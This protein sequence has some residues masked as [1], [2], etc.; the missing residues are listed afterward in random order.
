MGFKFNPLTG[1]LD[2]TN[3]PT[4]GG[5][6]IL[7]LNGLST[8]PQSLAI[9][10][11]ATSFTP[12][13]ASA[14]STHTLHIP[15]ASNAT[16][17]LVN[18]TGQDFYGRK[19]F[20]SESVDA[21]PSLRNTVEGTISPNDTVDSS[22]AFIAGV[23]GSAEGGSGIYDTGQLNGTLGFSGSGTGS[24]DIAAMVGV[25]AWAQTH[26]AYSGNVN[27]IYGSTSYARHLAPT[28][29]T[30]VIGHSAS[31][32]TEVVG[33]TQAYGLQVGS[34]VGG[35]GGSF[36]NAT[37]LHIGG[38][39]GTTEAIGIDITSL[40]G[41]SKIGIRANIAG[42]S[43]YLRDLNIMAG[44][45]L[46]FRDSDS[47]NYVSF[48]GAS[49]IASDIV[50]TLPSADGTSGQVLSTNGS[51][52]LSWATSSGGSSTFLALTD[53]P[54]S[55]TGQTL[56][57]VRVNAG[58][59]ALEFYTPSTTLT[60]GA[61]DT[62]TP[63][64]NALV[65]SG[66]SLYAQSAST[67]V[68]GMVNI[69]SQGFKGLKSLT[70]TL[71][72]PASSTNAFIVD[73][74]LTN[75]SNSSVSGVFSSSAS[76]FIVSDNFNHT[77]IGYLTGNYQ[78]VGT[79]GNGTYSNMHL[80]GSLSTV[81][82]SG[83]STHTS[84]YGAVCSV[85]QGTASTVG[86]LYGHQV[87]IANAV[88]STTTDMIGYHASVT[89]LSAAISN[90]YAFKVE[91]VSLSG[92]GNVYGFYND[93][94]GS[95]NV[96]SGTNHGSI[97]SG[98]N[99]VLSS[100]SHATK[101]VV[102]IAAGS[103]LQL[104]ATSGSNQTYNITRGNSQTL[105][106][107]GQKSGASSGFRYF[108]KDGDG[109]DS[110][111]W[112]L[113][114]VGTPGATT[115]S[116]VIGIGYD[117][118]NS[119]YAIQV[120]ATGTGVQ[121]PFHIYCGSDSNQMIFSTS[122]H[123]TIQDFATFENN[124]KE[125]EL[126]ATEIDKASGLYRR[127]YNQTV[128]QNTIDN[129]VDYYIV[130]AQN[131]VEKSDSNDETGGSLIGGSINQCDIS[132]TFT[133]ANTIFTG[134]L[135]ASTNYGSGTIE[136]QLGVG[137]SATN[138][139]SSGTIT[140]A[141]GVYGEVGNFQAGGTITNA[142]SVRASSFVDA[143]T[144]TNAYAFFAADG[145]I[146]GTNTWGIHIDQAGTKNVLHEIESKDQIFSTYA[147][148]TD[149]ANISWNVSTRQFAQVTLGGNRTLDNPTNIKAGTIYGIRVIQD[150]TGTRLLTWGSAYKHVGSVDPTL[151]VTAGSS[152]VFMFMS[153]GTNLWEVGRSLNAG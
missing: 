29:G 141:V 102:E 100:T 127:L 58:E 70:N 8:D 75:T 110:S 145:E 121:K 144:I 54:S 103:T 69:S 91:S 117:Q 113:F 9:G 68:P 37:G 36:D 149:A 89:A 38:I 20:N 83:T 123:V 66:S 48:K 95:M 111:N 97:S 116:E 147:T 24:G 134:G 115:N 77:G 135:C 14:G 94:A 148:L 126:T 106:L 61:I 136:Q 15:D 1:R 40:T 138:D 78:V 64:A 143:G 139:T 10:T 124:K 23:W 57:A 99:L 107:Q 96:L 98:G 101:G 60:I 34:I 13:W 108:T 62:Q 114:G 19:R 131:T 87:F 18:T 80:A 63:S 32:Q 92:T 11:S 6:G 140:T 151:T 28:V 93:D 52:T 82:N 35:S 153:D 84:M 88:G 81:A 30:V 4:I 55:Y 142:H 22:G 85:N 67:T 39:E 27:Y 73:T 129:A 53:T 125:L 76:S 65:I 109:T 51:G 56:K 132:G 112:Q 47:S 122:G 31:C 59:T 17:G 128:I 7:T 150:G 21:Y 90:A 105:D 2:L 130:G 16:R 137:G 42:S 3:P 133:S 74:T 50:W 79:T 72:N 152:D 146:V 118:T 33:V 104:T 45:E 12:Y 86:T 5:T 46:K 49:T 41:A 43:N 120:T 44:T 71:A 26:S 25:Y 119:R